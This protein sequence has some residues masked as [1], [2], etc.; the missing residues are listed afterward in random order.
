MTSYLYPSNIIDYIKRQC[1]LTG[2]KI[3]FKLFLDCQLIISVLLYIVLIYF[4]INYI[5]ALFIVI[6][7]GYL[8][9]YLVIKQKINR[10][11]KL[12]EKDSVIFFE[13]L[14]LSLAS[15]AN[16]EIAIKTSTEN[17]DNSIS[18]E[19]KK[20][21]LDLKFGKTLDEAL[22]DLGNQLPSLVIKNTIT[23]IHQS[24]ILGT[25]IITSLYQQIDYLQTKYINDIKKKAATVP[26]KISIISVFIFIPIIMLLVLGPVI[27]NYIK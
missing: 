10:R 18:Y 14:V 2:K 7:I 27:I 9:Y 26:L 21:L 3:S 12:L 23:N 25:D 6:L 16:L 22:T 13:A 5:V 17:I 19:F 8:M 24:L 1:E 4:K 15:G 11:T 20:V